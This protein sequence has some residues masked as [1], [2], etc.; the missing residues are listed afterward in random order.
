MRILLKKLKERTKGLKKQLLVIYYVYK[1]G[2]IARWKKWL[3][4]IVIGYAVSPID[5]IPDFIPVLG[6]LDDLILVPF[7]IYVAFKLIPKKELEEAKRKT[8][9]TEEH[10]IPIG[11]KTA[12]IILL[13]WIAG[14]FIIALWVSQLL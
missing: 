12:V 13:L 8:D 5:I 10:N 6:Y 1:E 4:A 3:I 7:G 9:N 14:F 11:K 2:K